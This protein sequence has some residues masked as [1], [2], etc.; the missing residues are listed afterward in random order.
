MEVRT[1]KVP[2]A[3]IPIFVLGSSPMAQNLLTSCKDASLGPEKIDRVGWSAACHFISYGRRIGIRTNAPSLLDRLPPLLPPDWESI[4]GPSV[5]LLVSLWVSGR[6]GGQH[7][8]YLGP[9]CA[10]RTA[11]L[12]YLLETLESELQLYVGEHARDR[13]FVHAGVVCCNGRALLLPGRSMAGKS[14]LV[15]ALVRAGATYYSDEYAVLDDYGKVYPYARRLSLR[16][17]AGTPSRRCTA[18]ELGGRRGSGPLPVKLIAV[19]KYQ[20]GVRWNPRRLPPGQTLLELVSHTLPTLTYPERA[21]SALQQITP[22]AH[23]L[24]GW[25]GAA[26][27]TAH[28]LLRELENGS[29]PIPPFTSQG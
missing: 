3:L 9:K 17:R 15:E 13:V 14:T 16:P 26:E 1:R 20:E 2:K 6:P 11:D 12:D 5:E 25:R 29:I 8:L 23:S 7:R 22:Q 18:E 28:A 10:V 24:K 19:T 4:E 27:E 21:L